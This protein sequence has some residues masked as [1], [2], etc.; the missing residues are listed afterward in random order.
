MDR[1][2]EE[3]NLFF[4]TLRGA[5]GLDEL[6]DVFYFC[7][8]GVHKLEADIKRILAALGVLVVGNDPGLDFPG[9]LAGGGGYFNHHHRSSAGVVVQEQMV[10]SHL[11]LTGLE[12]GPFFRNRG[13]ASPDFIGPGPPGKRI[14][15]EKIHIRTDGVTGIPAALAAHVFLNGFHGLNFAGKNPLPGGKDP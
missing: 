15:D 2:V 3:K 12:A 8:G 9:R 1:K 7:G 5:I 6:L 4:F 14:P 11:E 13:N 10:R